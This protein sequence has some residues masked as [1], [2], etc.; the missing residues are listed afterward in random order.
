MYT[1]ILLQMIDQGVKIMSLSDV[2]WRRD[3]SVVAGL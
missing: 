1:V 3:G 2:V